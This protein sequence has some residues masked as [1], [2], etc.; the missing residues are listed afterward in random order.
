MDGKIGK[1]FLGM[2]GWQRERLDYPK[3]KPLRNGLRK[4]MIPN[5]D[6]KF[7]LSGRDGV[8]A[9]TADTTM[10]GIAPTRC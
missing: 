2:Y 5:Y 4:A 9:D 7:N 1:C 10:L 6:V 8:G 3:T